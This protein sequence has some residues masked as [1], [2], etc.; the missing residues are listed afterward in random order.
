MKVEVVI[1]C[2]IN[3]RPKKFAITNHL[4]NLSCYSPKEWAIFPFEVYIQGLKGK[5]FDK[6]GVV[7][8]ANKVEVKWSIKHAG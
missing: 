5:K 3:G 1:S 8:D 7:C 4:G 2:D 6:N